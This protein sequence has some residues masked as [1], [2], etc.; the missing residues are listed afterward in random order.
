MRTP[1]TTAPNRRLGRALI[2]VVLIAGLSA[3]PYSAPGRDPVM[4]WN[5]I[6]REFVVVPALTPV[7]Q[8]RAMAIVQLAVHD[9]VNA[10][11]GRYER[12]ASETLPPPDAG[13]E[14]AAIGAAYAALTGVI[15]AS[16]ALN[17]RYDQSVAAFAIPPD[18]P[19]LA[20]GKAVAAEIL[21]LRNPSA[22][23]SANA[24]FPYTAPGAGSPGVWQPVSAAA[25]AQA[26]LPG[27]G[28][29]TPFVLRSA[30]QFRPDPP[31]ALGSERYA[32]DY[33]EVRELGS[34]GSLVR[35]DEQT[36]IALF[37][38]ASPT[39]IWNPI[40]RQAI[41]TRGLPPAEAARVIALFYLAS[42]DASIACWEAKYYYNFWRPQAAIAGGGADGN[43]ATITEPGWMPRLP[44]APHPEFPSGH[45]SN[46]GAM[47]AVLQA[48]FGDAPGFVIEATSAQ[49]PGLI[50]R[51]FTFNEGVDEVID[52][53]IYSGIHF[54]TADEVGA[55]LGRQVAQFTLTHALR[56]VRGPQRLP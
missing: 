18:D 56:P 38:R 22:D 30:D 33:N 51:W 34:F 31:P 26:L 2:L 32:R 16:D 37:W 35:T 47:A 4:D 55:R 1:E 28:S 3:G 45:T 40:L 53:R 25:A 50:R 7:E 11:T 8:T 27:W 19:G 6:A 13:L 10:I 52:A 23:G 15:G 20:F 54:R 36:Q 17:G 39:A 21:A 46:S 24:R 49:N 9:A 43:D 48:F 44:T 12:Y 5:D 29:V 42:A 41:L 14:A